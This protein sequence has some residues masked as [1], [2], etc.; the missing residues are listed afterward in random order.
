VR[1]H[2]LSSVIWALEQ[3]KILGWRWWCMPVIPATQEVEVEVLRFQ[4]DPGKVRETL[5]EKQTKTK[6]DW[7]YG[8]SGRVL[9][10]GGPQFN[11]PTT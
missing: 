5:S 2:L 3:T 4:A 11:P 10:A 8:S 7:G 1:K 9:E 6:K